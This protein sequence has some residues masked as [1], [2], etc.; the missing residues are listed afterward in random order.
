MGNTADT[1]AKGRGESAVPGV[2]RGRGQRPGGCLRA[3]TDSKSCPGNPGPSC[4]TG[5]TEQS[6]VIGLRHLSLA[7]RAQGLGVSE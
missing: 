2:S 5:N 6:D 1:Y 3:R 4:Q 7:W